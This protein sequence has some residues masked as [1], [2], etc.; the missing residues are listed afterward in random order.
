M[1]V[2]IYLRLTGT[3]RDYRDETTD[4]VSLSKQYNSDPTFS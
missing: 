3:G 1:S 2:V 4:K